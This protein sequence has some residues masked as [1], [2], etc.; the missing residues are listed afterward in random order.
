M[1]AVDT[2]DKPHEFLLL[3]L[4]AGQRVYLRGAAVDILRDADA[5]EAAAGASAIVTIDG[6]ELPLAEDLDS[7]L[8]MLE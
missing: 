3:H 6:L 4:P 5:E 8:A 2:R 1:T 7:I